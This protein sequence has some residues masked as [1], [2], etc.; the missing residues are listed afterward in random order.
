MGERRLPRRWGTGRTQAQTAE[1]FRDEWFV[2]G[3]LISIDGDGY[4]THR[5][6]ADDAIKVKGKWLSPQE[7][8]SCLLEHERSRSA[9]W[10]PSRTTTA[11]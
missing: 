11:F 8:E 3:D 2:G 5:G 1:A 6:R 7:V 9:R 10:W 4:V